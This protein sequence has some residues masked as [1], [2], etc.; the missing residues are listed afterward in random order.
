MSWTT[1]GA[2]NARPGLVLFGAEHRVVLIGES[3][4]TQVDGLRV[5]FGEPILIRGGRFYISLLD[6]QGRLTPFIRPELCGHAPGHPRVIAIDPGHGGTDNGM[7]NPRLALKEKVYTLDVALELRK[8]LEAAGYR[9][10]MTRTSDKNVEL[11]MRAEIANTQGADLFVSIHFNAGAPSDTRTRGTE[12]FTFT[13][14]SQRSDESWSGRKD[15]RETA[16]PV[17]RFDAWSQVLAE[18]IHRQVLGSLHT[19]DRGQKTKH[20]AALRGLNCPA[21]LVES[22]F[23]SN[24]AEGALVATPAFRTRLAEALLA[25]IRD[26]SAELDRL[27]PAPA[28]PSHPQ[29]P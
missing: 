6:Y 19:E 3:R 26:Y 2:A 22:A 18:C 17:N 24:D 13:L 12:V 7:Q 21:I 15:D 1:S 11:P 20:L 5:F 27:Q 14:P 4:D 16:S 25:G 9:V 10:V 8:L 28:S 29:R 23:L